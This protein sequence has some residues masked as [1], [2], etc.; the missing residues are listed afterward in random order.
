MLMNV[1]VEAT[2]DYHKGNIHIKNQGVT[3]CVINYDKVL[4]HGEETVVKPGDLIDLTFGTFV[5]QIRA[6]TGPLPVREHAPKEQQNTSAAHKVE[7]KGVVI[8]NP[9]QQT[10]QISHTFSAEEGEE[11]AS[12]GQQPHQK[13]ELNQSVLEEMMGKSDVG[14]VVSSSTS[15]TPPLQSHDKKKILDSDWRLVEGFLGSM[16]VLV[17]GEG[18]LN[19]KP[20]VAG[21]DLDFTIIKPGPGLDSSDLNLTKDPLWEFLYPSTPKVLKD[22]FAAHSGHK[23][24][25]VTN[26]ANAGWALFSK[27][28]IEEVVLE[29]DIPVIVFAAKEVILLL[30]LSMS[31]I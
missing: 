5:Y 21:F 8:R 4:R 13:S 26:K 22:F 3:K 20:K 23:F 14:M 9:V 15:A 30:L 16:P 1:S 17:Y 10:S 18:A 2:A 12:D 11:A 24:V 29:L 28:I 6:W 19:T 27:R 25:I 31:C 7:G